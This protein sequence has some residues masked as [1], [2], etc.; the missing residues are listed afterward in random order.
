MSASALN[1]RRIIERWVIKGDLELTTPAHLGNGEEGMGVD[2]PVFLDA[3]GAPL[4]TGDSLAGALRNYLRDREF[5]YFAELIPQGETDKEEARKEARD[6]ET[7]SLSSCLFGGISGDDLGEQSPLIVED[8]IGQ[9]MPRMEIRDG[10][11]IA[12]ATCTA[13]E[14]AKFDFELLEAGT[15]FGLCFELLFTEDANKEEASRGRLE[16][17]LAICLEGLE[18]GEI[19]IGAKKSRGFGKCK[20]QGWKIWKFNLQNPKDLLQYLAFGRDGWPDDPEGQPASGMVSQLLSPRALDQRAY[21]DLHAKFDL[22]DSLLIRSGSP[23]LEKDSSGTKELLNA[24]DAVHLKSLRDGDWKSI[25]SGTSVAGAVRH[26]AQKILRTLGLGETPAQ[27]FIDAVFGPEISSNRK[28]KPAASRLLVEETLITEPVE[29]VHTRV[30]IDPFT[31]GAFETGLF[32]EQP[33]FGGEKTLL[34]LEMR[35]RLDRPL[36]GEVAKP[37]GDNNGAAARSNPR[38]GFDFRDRDVQNAAIGLLLLCLKDLWTED[39][40]VGGEAS[41][42]RGRLKGKHAEI[43]IKLP[44]QQSEKQYV[45]KGADKGVISVE[46]SKDDLEGFVKALCG[47]VDSRQK[48]VIAKG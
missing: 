27:D 44:D 12:P 23:S 28:K 4:L 22:P 11:R 25:L 15:R 6:R 14:H 47:L 17:A 48:P 34:R 19:R 3:Y 1:V 33:V 39:L 10:V 43:Q 29:L 40:P 37:S 32:S 31:G 20:V 7:K 21:F 8:A 9:V 2:M 24:P 30:R 38:E 18:K 5:G 35:L 42:G 36:G 45:I 26:R 46:G 16:E 13:A 41:V